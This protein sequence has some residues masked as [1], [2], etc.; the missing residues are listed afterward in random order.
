MIIVFV[1][2]FNVFDRQQTTIPIGISNGEKSE[3][4][5]TTRYGLPPYILVI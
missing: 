4:F 5:G 3:N 1:L 2:S